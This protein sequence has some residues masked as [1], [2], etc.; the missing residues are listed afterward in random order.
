MNSPENNL[1]IRFPVKIFLRDISYNYTRGNLKEP[2]F[3]ELVAIEKGPQY[4]YG[5]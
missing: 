1:K 4:K 2:Y 5:K 3:R